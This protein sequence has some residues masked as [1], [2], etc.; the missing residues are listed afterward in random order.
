MQSR[1]GELKT[2]PFHAGT[3]KSDVSN[4]PVV[5]QRDRVTHAPELVY[6]P[7]LGFRAVTAGLKV[8]A[9]VVVELASGEQVPDGDEH[10]MFRSD[11]RFERSS[12]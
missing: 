10:G 9:G 8:S 4:L 3:V 7:S 2:G 1:T 11:D 6:G 12:P 5:I